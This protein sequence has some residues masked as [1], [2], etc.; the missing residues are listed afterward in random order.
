M[1]EVKA[2]IKAK[3]STD[4]Q[5]GH[6]ATC[7][8][9][10]CTPGSTQ[11]CDCSPTERGVQICNDEGSKFGPCTCTAGGTQLCILQNSIVKINRDGRPP[12]KNQ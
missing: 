7:V 4:I 11:A 6:A 8:V 9:P 5:R 12:Y 10:V 1:E 3:L 2:A